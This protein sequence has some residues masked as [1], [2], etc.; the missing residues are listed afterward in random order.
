MI[1]KLIIGYLE[2]IIFQLANCPI[3]LFYWFY[4]FNEVSWKL[5]PNVF[6]KVDSLFDEYLVLVA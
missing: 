4:N 3:Y 5:F 1:I 6:D 2:T